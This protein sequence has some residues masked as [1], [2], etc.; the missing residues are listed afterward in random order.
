MAADACAPEVQK[1][2]RPM[3]IFPQQ[4]QEARHRLAISQFNYAYS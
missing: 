2:E 4:Y 3:G 1:C